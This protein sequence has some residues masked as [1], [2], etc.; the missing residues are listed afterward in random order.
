MKQLSSMSIHFDMEKDLRFQQGVLLGVEQ[1]I[2]QG[3][4]QGV[5]LGVKQGAQQESLKNKQQFATTLILSTDFDDEKISTFV[6]VTV[7]YAKQLRK[8]LND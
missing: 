5:P 4:E 6:G 2:E 8:S 7:D 3:I 1:G